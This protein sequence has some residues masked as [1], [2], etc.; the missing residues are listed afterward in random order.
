VIKPGLLVVIIAVYGLFVYLGKSFFPNVS[1][2]KYN[3]KVNNYFG[4]ALQA[5]LKD[6][7]SFR[8]KIR[9]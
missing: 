6:F 2:K 1:W 8:K 9:V 5:A 3:I 4:V 7:Y